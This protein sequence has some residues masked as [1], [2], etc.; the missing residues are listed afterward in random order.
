MP[1]DFATRLVHLLRPALVASLMLLT[2]CFPGMY[3]GHRYQQPMYAPPRTLNPG[4]LYI[5]Q[6]N[7]PP[8]VPDSNSTYDDDPDD[9]K[10]AND[11]N[12]VPLPNDR[13]TPFF[14]EDDDDLGPS[15]Q[16]KDPVDSESAA[17]P[18]SQV[19]LAESAPEYGFDRG[20]YQWLRGV[21]RRDPDG[22]V[23]KIV[24]SM[25]ATDS[26]SGVLPLSVDSTLLNGLQSGDSI[27]VRGA[28]ATDSGSGEAYYRVDD[29]QLLVSDPTS[30]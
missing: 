27:E 9:F 13:D 4:G 6:S 30:R 10:K 15:T 3:M 24:Y 26:Y 29:L 16:L 1:S 8:Y 18:V 17:R 5:P 20:E 14:D 7:A 2:G 28:V 22:N 21:L 12:G 25:A 11:E 23:W 19:S